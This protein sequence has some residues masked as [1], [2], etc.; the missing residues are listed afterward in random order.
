[1]PDSGERFHFSL[2]NIIGKGGKSIFICCHLTVLAALGFCVVKDIREYRIPSEAI[3]TGIL[4]A[5][6]GTLAAG[7][8]GA[9]L[10]WRAGLEFLGRFILIVVLAAPFWVLRMTGAG[11]VKVMALIVA[12]MGFSHGLGAIGIGLILG[13]VLALGKML[14]HGSV[15][16]RFPYLISYFRKIIREKEIDFYYD[17]DRDGRRCVIPLGAC[18]CAGALVMAVWKGGWM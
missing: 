12:W 18:F 14:H 2:R 16:Q 13:A 8:S 3:L 1:M 11:D 6:L 4:A 9:A 7:S 17:A 5:L 10:N 15:C